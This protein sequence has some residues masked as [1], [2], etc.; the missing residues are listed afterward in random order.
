[1]LIDRAKLFGADL[2]IVERAGGLDLLR[3]AGADLAL[4]V[5]NDNIAQALALRLR[6]RKGELGLLGWADYGSRLHELIGEPNNTRTHVKLMA[7]A[8]AALEQDPRV[9]EVSAIQ[10]KVLPG[11]R[12]VVRLLL[13][14][15]LID[16]P[17]PLNFVFDVK[18][19]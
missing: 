6:V 13:E 1:M 15:L 19:N 7:F 2:Q 16:G 5:G 14:I 9:R 11:E 3:D 8:R 18:L 4:A 12:D 17:N 10:A